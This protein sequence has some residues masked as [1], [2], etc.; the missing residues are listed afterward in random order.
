[1]VKRK[2]LNQ[3]S[4]GV[5]VFLFYCLT[6]KIYVVDPTCQQPSVR[7]PWS[8]GSAEPVLICDELDVDFTLESVLELKWSSGDDVLATEKVQFK[9][10][11][12]SFEPHKAAAVK[13]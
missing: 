12:G 9:D 5:D 4:Y 6:I 2:H 10:M 3:L 7:P 8:H 11:V 1:M 13:M